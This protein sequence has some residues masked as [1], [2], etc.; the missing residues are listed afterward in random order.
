M[1]FETVHDKL[2]RL[3]KVINGLGVTLHDYE[4]ASGV[5]ADRLLFTRHADGTQTIFGYDEYGH[6]SSITDA[7]NNTTQT[8][9][10]AR[11]LTRRKI[12][13][14]GRITTYDYDNFGRNILITDP[15][16][17]KTRWTMMTSII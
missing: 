8:V 2:G 5:N 13:G 11:G 3:D 16:G 7:S 12:D 9:I 1:K 4:Y 17:M 15:S 10:D 6:Q 14:E